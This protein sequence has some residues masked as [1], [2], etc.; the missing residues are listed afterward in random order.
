[1]R[2]IIIVCSDRLMSAP[3][4]EMPVRPQPPGVHFSILFN[5]AASGG[6]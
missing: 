4:T 2:R 6:K 1:M 3:E 5:V